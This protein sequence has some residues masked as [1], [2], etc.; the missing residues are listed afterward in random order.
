MRILVLTPAFLPI[1]GGAEIVLLE[2]YR[3]LSTRHDVLLLTADKGGGTSDMDHLINFPVI[4][5]KDRFTTMRFRGHRKTGGVV[6]PFSLSAVKAAGQAL[7]D[8]RPDVLN[9]HYMSPTGLATVV[10]QK[11]FRVPSVLTF[12]GRDVP[13][14][15]T[16]YCWKHYGR[17]VAHRL[18]DVTYVT[19]YCRRA[20]FG[21][22]EA[23]PGHVI[24]AGIDLERFHPKIDGAGVRQSFDLA[25]ETP[26]LFAMQRLSA[27]KR[28]DVVINAMPMILQKHPRAVLVIGGSGPSKSDLVSLTKKL[29]LEH[30]VRFC[31][32]IPDPDLPRYYAAAD[33]FVFHS[34]FETFGIVLAEAMATAKAVVSVNST[35]IPDVVTNGE[36][37]MLVPPHDPE[38][39]AEKVIFL[40]DNPSERERLGKN[41]REWA[42]NHFDWDKIAGQY[43]TVLEAAAR[44][45]T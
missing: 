16:P 41:G 37:G 11:R 1:V 20:L 40:L 18:A 36:T 34:T 12:T 28:V 13:G 23:P 3:R 42:E 8:F 27:E 15:G 29:G 32:Y 5:Y 33:M 24:L 25:P 45:K 6:P 9:T 38:A 26:L 7:R 17:W 4:R 14:P 22:S 44:G 39:L 35:A 30:S 43:E 31:G 19:D 2:V 10:A 21:D